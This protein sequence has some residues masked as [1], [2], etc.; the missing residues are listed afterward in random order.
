LD[1]AVLTVFGQAQLAGTIGAA[2]GLGHIECTDGDIVPIKIMERKLHR[3][4]IGIHMWLFLQPVNERARPWQG[5]VKV[6]D[7]EEQ[8]EAIARFGVVGACQR[9]MFVGAPLVETEQNRSIGIENLSEVLVGGR[10]LW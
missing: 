10:R 6:V 9:G 8:E 3:S 4:C 1:Y 2:E 5:Y 7:P